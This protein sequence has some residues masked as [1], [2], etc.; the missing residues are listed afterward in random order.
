MYRF[1]ETCETDAPLSKTALDEQLDVPWY[2]WDKANLGRQE[3]IAF[4][5]AHD[6]ESPSH[7][8][9]H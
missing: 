9:R 2:S 5:N 7:R 4:H 1:Y 3:L 8:L 6:L